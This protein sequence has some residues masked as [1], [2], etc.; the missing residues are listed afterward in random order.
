MGNPGVFSLFAVAAV[1]VLVAGLYSIMVSK[2]LIRT[3]IG[4]EILAKSVTLLIITAGYFAKRIALAQTLAITII[5][6]EVAV[7]VVAV[8]MVLGLFRHE[9]SIDAGIVR[10]LKG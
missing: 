6:I 7:T 8:G 1:L 10:H 4:V 5:I 3:L 9:K 2:D